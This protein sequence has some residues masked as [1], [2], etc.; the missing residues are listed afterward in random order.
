MK[1]VFFW[2]VISFGSCK[3]RR[4]G[5]RYRLQHL[6]DKNQRARNNVYS[7]QL[8]SLSGSYC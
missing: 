1:N 5:E 6:S 8:P 7:N 3:N 4:F 2:D